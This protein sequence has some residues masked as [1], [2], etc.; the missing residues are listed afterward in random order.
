MKMRED[1][2]MSEDE[3]FDLEEDLDLD[4]LGP[5]EDED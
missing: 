5:D 4:A 3:K 2:N 1:K